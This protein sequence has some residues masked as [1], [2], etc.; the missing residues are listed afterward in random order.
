MEAAARRRLPAGLPA[1][2]GPRCQPAGRDGCGALHAYLSLVPLG[3]STPEPGQL[4][5]RGAAPQHAVR[6]PAKILLERPVG[7]GPR[8]YTDEQTLP[9]QPERVPDQV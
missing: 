1:H 4:G 7:V 6:S 9:K 2:R 3:L 8:A 5:S